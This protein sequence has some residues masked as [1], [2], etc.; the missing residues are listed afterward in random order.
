MSG[1][2]LV[3]RLV[4]SC[5]SDRPIVTHSAMTGN[6][7]TWVPHFRPRTRSP[8]GYSPGEPARPQQHGVQC[9]VFG[10]RGI[11]P[12]EPARPQQQGIQCS[13]S[14]GSEKEIYDIDGLWVDRIS[15]REVG[16]QTGRASH[17]GV[18]HGRGVSHGMDGHV[19]SS[20]LCPEFGTEVLVFSMIRT[21]VPHLRPRARV[22][23]DPTGGTSWPF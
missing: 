18:P 22:A 23:M 3:R 5:A 17:K 14:A 15:S 21:W 4:A 9:S 13:V 6:R 8:N 19:S 12:G 16:A 11:G 1:R 2:H 10:V 20:E 7:G